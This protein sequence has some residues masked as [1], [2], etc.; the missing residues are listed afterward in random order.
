MHPAPI[1]GYRAD[2]C[3]TH[4]HAAKDVDVLAMHK[5]GM[6]PTSWRS[7]GA[8]VSASDNVKYYCSTRRGDCLQNHTIVKGKNEGS[9]L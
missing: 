8:C 1:D 2:C 5:G 6:A 7:P 9:S 3:M 4:P